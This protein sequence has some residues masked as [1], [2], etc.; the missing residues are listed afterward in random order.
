MGSGVSCEFTLDVDSVAEPGTKVC[1]SEALSVDYDALLNEVLEQLRYPVSLE[2]DQLVKTVDLKELGPDSF[3]AKV[4]FNG[5]K[6]TAMKLNDASGVD[7]IAVWVKT[8]TDRAARTLETE[9]Y[10]M[11]TKAIAVG[12]PEDCDAPPVLFKGVCNFLADPLRVEYHIVNTDGQRMANEHAV[13][14]VKPTLVASLDSLAKTKVQVTPDLESMRTPGAKSAVTDALDDHISFD[15]LYDAILAFIRA[16]LPNIPAP[17]IEEVS[18]TEFVRSDKIYGPTGTLT[19][20]VVARVL[21]VKEKNEITVQNQMD[22]KDTYA[23]WYVFHKDPLQ[24]EMWVD[25][26]E[27]ERRSGRSIS[28]ILKSIVNTSIEKAS[29]S[30]F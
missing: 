6:L 15:A 30:W 10:A 11:P 16:P 7:Q 12:S 28:R 26:A 29:S 3:V 18:P 9:T 4:I 13:A 17:E 5:E 14:A 25:M 27:G 2:M 21:H 23:T 20:T 24:V 8:V 22:G 1:V 19:A